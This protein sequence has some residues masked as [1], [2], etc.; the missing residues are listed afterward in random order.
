VR[1][2]SG[3]E[4][5]VGERSG[6]QVT[7]TKARDEASGVM[8]RIHQVLTVKGDQVHTVTP[9]SSVRDV[10]QLLSQHNI[11]AVVVSDSSRA[12]LGIVSERDVVRRLLST[13]RLLD[14]PVS[15][16][17]TTKVY[18]CGPDDDLNKLMAVMTERRVRHIPVVVNGSLH[19]IVS[20]GDMVKARMSELEFERDQ[21]ETYVSG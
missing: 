17:M 4:Q 6:K 10:V 14:R 13:D 3:A 16:I 7:S 20:I 8:M 21:L 2:V 1:S 12:V 18:T 9:D 5:G 15:D 19:G 11:G